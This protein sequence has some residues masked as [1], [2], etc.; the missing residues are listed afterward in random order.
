MNEF[1]YNS[2]VLQAMNGILSSNNYNIPKEELSQKSFAIADEFI[3]EF[4]R[5]DDLSQ[6]MAKKQE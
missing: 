2:L 3:K 4:K 6:E 5:R 1:L